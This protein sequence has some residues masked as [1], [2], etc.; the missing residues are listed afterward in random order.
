VE[1]TIRKV[2]EDIPRKIEGVERITV[3]VIDDGSTDATASIAQACGA[4]VYSHKIKKGLGSVFYSATTKALELNADVLVSVDADD[5][6]TPTEIPNLILPIL[7]GDVDFVIGNR[8]WS[9]SRPENMPFVKYWG[10]RQVSKVLSI[11]LKKKV[12]DVSCGFRAYSKEALL[13][14]NLIDSFTYTHATLLELDAK[15]LN[16]IEVPVFVS[17]SPE[18]V[19]RLVY[20]IVGYST[21]TLKNFLK[22]VHL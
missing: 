14:L 4:Y 5:Q 9:G 3:L 22:E 15:K 16:F 20:S 17:Y 19:S 6:F 2:I 12:N 21:Q 1:R 18:R 11:L 10:N 13:H 7:N 8:F